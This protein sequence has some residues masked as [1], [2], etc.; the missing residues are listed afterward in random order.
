M[1]LLQRYF[2]SQALWPLLLSLSALA[3]LALLTQSL[4]TLDIIVENR[5][6]AVTFL[7]I[8]ILAL[9]QLIACLLYTSPSPRDRG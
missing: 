7:Y 6:S 9:P 4:Q 1:T 2:W 5:E 3:S 8:T